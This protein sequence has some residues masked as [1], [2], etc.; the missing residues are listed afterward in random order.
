MHLERPDGAR[1]SWTSDGD[2]AA[3]PVLLVMGLAYPAAMWF[4]V[5]PVLAER[6]RVLRLDNRGAGLTGEVP[7]AP[8]TVP[9]MAGDCLA[10]LDA[11]G[12]DRAHVVGI[13]MGG[14]ISQEIVH[15]A[16]ERVRSLCLMATHPG[17]AHA[18]WDPEALAVLSNRGEM[19]PQEAAEQS[20]PFNYA[21][22]TPRER[23]E[24]DWAVRLP[25]AATPAGY[26]AQLAGAS[27]WDGYDRL[28]S[29]TTPTLVVHGTLDR[30][31]PPA[32]GT[33]IAERVPGARLELVEDANHLLFTDQPEQV[34][35][36]LLDWLDGQA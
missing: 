16:P 13:S 7:G 25:L 21:P 22:G 6:Y 19:T 35:R 27:Q 9:T 20:I 32:N 34:K 29:V 10:V 1:I 36:V 11:A 31:V 15:T 4:R 5:V 17:T 26:L 23:M 8:Y 30:L 2:D 28:P 18:V 24:E 33:T 3:P 14:L 12:V